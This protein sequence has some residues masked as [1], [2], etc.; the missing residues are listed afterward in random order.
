MRSLLISEASKR[1]STPAGFGLAQRYLTRLD[2]SAGD[3]YS[4][5]FLRLLKMQRKKFITLPHGVSEINPM[6]VEG[7]VRYSALFTDLARWHAGAVSFPQVTLC[8]AS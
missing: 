8:W 7:K 3:K 5:L 2:R 4:N 6:F 1:C